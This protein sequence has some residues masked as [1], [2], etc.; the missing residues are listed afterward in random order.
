MF[1]VC[2][3]TKRIVSALT[4]FFNS[5]NC[6]GIVLGLSGG[7]DS[8]VC[9]KFL[10][11]S[12]APQKITVLL[13]P[14]ENKNQEELI[15]FAQE[16]GVNHFVIELNPLL[17]EFKL[18]WKQNE[19]SEMNLKARLRMLLLYNYANSNNY[20]VCGT[21]NKSELILGYF[22]KHGDGAVDFILLGNY[23]KTQVYEIAKEL[24]VPEKIINAI[25][26]AGLK[27]GQSDELELGAKY[28]VIDKILIELI[29]N[30]KSIQEISEIGFNKKLIE[31][32]SE[33]IN[34]NKHKLILPKIL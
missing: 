26:T 30:K 25:P 16:C 29:E 18:Q 5:S 33:R 34:K 21:G 22:T 31:S 8:A 3:E 28:S 15:K 32:L 2:A 17:R 24:H 27:K 6:K 4:A 13:M 20:L 23:W 7:I 12:I 14:E 1:N 11:K 9:L 10:I 19:L